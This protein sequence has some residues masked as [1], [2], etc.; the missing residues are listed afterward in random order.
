MKAL[1]VV[2]C[3]LYTSSAVYGNSR[4]RSSSSSTYT[5]PL[6]KDSDGFYCPATLSCVS[7]TLR[8]TGD[9]SAPLCERK[10]YQDCNYDSASGNFRVYRHSTPLASSS[11]SSRGLYD[12]LVRDNKLEHQFITYRGLMYEFGSY[13]SRVQDPLDPHYEYKTREIKDSEYLGP[14][15]CTYEEVVEFTK[16]WVDYSLCSHNCQDFARGLGKYLLQTIKE[17]ESTVR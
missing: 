9:Y 14:S 1:V 2:L 3:L 6:C 10:T 11:S 17:T 12:C 15:T 4:I 13:G 8:C 5:T 7:R 16:T